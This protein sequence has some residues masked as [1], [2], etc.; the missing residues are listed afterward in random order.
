[1]SSLNS[2][3]MQLL[4][5]APIPAMLFTL[6]APNVVATM[7][8]TASTFADAWYVGEL[9]TAELASLALVF[10]FQALMI[11]M[12][13]GAIGG[14][15]TSAM[16]RALGRG[17]T[18]GAQSVAWHAVVIAA[19]FSTV[20]T[21]SLGFFSRPVFALLGGTGTALEGAVVYAHIIFSGAI[22][23]WMLWVLSAVLRGTGDTVTP[24]R[25]ILVSGLA[26][27]GLSG[28]LTLG[29]WGFPALGIAGPPT[30]T[31]VCHGL[32]AVYLAFHLVSGRA[33]I[34]LQ[35]SRIKYEP[36]AEI[37]RVGGLGLIN[38]M[39][40]AF[41]V[42]LV[43]GFVGRYGIEALAGYGL[44]SR[45][46]LMLVPFAFGIGGA[47]T[48]AVGA[49]FGASQFARARRCAWTGAGVTLALVG[50][51]GLLVAWMPELWLGLFTADAKAYEFGALYLCIAGPVYGLFG[52]GQTLYFASQGT[53]RM[54][55]PV[56][57]GVTRLVAV[58]TIG[59]LALRY[60]WPVSAVFMGVAVGLTIIGVGTALCM[61]TAA[62]R[63]E[64]AR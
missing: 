34:R 2:P 19:V 38:S 30:A 45:L 49:N 64:L 56:M 51:V 6:A 22:C 33:A 17:D 37:M 8:M 40:I 36:I 52:A 44:G 43:T 27:I 29:W 10:P 3:R 46:E 42:I 21:V 26:Q 4:L 41:T 58:A 53:G 61:R 23:V 11:M 24:A 28:A 14:G 32:A 15:V 62:W 54:F 31:I 25:A 18:D 50:T 20:F 13:G 1:M 16:S 5:H 57:V 55:F 35:F 60:S 48:V 59:F 63:P 12:C 7:T 39:S 47:L 9:G